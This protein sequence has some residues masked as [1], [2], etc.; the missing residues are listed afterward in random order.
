MEVEGVCQVPVTMV[1]NQ[2]DSFWS[3]M[4]NPFPGRGSHQAQ[5]TSLHVFASRAGCHYFRKLP[6]GRG[7][8]VLLWKHEARIHQDV[9]VI[10]PYQHAVHPDLAQPAD[11]EHPE[12]WALAG[13]RPRELLGGPVL[14]QDRAQVVLPVAGLVLPPFWGCTHMLLTL[15]AAPP[16]VAS[17]ALLLRFAL[18]LLLCW[19]RRCKVERVSD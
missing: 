6:G 5:K 1:S 4:R 14:L 13:G 11:G 16:A 2:H 17:L 10:H 12:G 18:L 8:G 7:R 15:S 3:L 19:R 9:A